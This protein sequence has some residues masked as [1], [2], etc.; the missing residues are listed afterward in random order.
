MPQAGGQGRAA[1]LSA[2]E[3]GT[4][5][6]ARSG[7]VKDSAVRA[8]L[9]A[10][11]RRKTSW[12]RAVEL[13]DFDEAF[14]NCPQCNSANVAPAN[15]KLLCNDCG[16]SFEARAA[17]AEPAPS[18]AGPHLI[19]CPACAREVSS[20]A[21]RCPTCGQPL[22]SVVER[23]KIGSALK[24]GFFVLTAGLII[25]FAVR[26]YLQNEAAADAALNAI[27]GPGK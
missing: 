24:W 14:M 6:A 17:A 19:K 18:S 23:K 3:A 22:R 2:C 20:Q 1:A 25:F 13:R 7:I 21:M 27:T 12:P 9:H 10:G 4:W 26:Q 15:G 11:S 8:L 5:G 16:N